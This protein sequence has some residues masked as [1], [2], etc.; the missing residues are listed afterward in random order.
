M[1]KIIALVIILSAYGNHACAQLILGK[2]REVAETYLTLILKGQKEET[3]QLFD[4]ANVPTVTKEQF[5]AAFTQMQSGLSLFDTFAFSS[6]VFQKVKNKKFNLYRFKVLS[7]NK[8][9]LMDVVVDLIFHDTSEL[10]AGMQW[11]ARRNDSTSI[12]SKNKETPIEKPFTAVVDSIS[13]NIRG[14]NIIHFS[15]N[16]G[17]LAIQVERKISSDEL[18]K[19]EWTKKE[20]VKFAKYLVS[21]GYVDKAKLKA[22]ELELTLVEDLGV[23][24]ID[25]GSGQGINIK[26]TPEDF[27]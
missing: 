10:V 11:I 22:K 13:Y 16:I 17:L 9:V 19:Q 14:I 6:V 18:E 12:T 24:F 25:P 2:Q 7:K 5:A 1:I 23:S 21:K 27:K 15:N 3:W 8:N 20:A 4:K 26:L